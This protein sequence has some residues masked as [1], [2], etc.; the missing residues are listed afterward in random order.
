MISFGT[1]I[2][3]D[4]IKKLVEYQNLYNREQEIRKKYQ[5]EEKKMDKLLADNATLVARKND[6]EMIIYAT[7]KKLEEEQQKKLQLEQRLKEL[8][9]NKDKVK[10]T[11]QIK[12]WEKEMETLQQDLNMIIHQ[13]DYETHKQTDTMEELN[14]VNAKMLENDAKIKALRETIAAI[15]AKHKDELTYILETQKNI[16]S[17]FDV[18]VIEYFILLLRKTKGQAIVSV[19]DGD[20]CSG[21][22]TI[23]PTVIQGEIGPNLPEEEIELQQCPHC[24]RFLYYPQWLD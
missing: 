8:D 15:E 17:E 2:R 22:Y 16:A 24:F 6:L 12:T 21:C 11:R 18:S 23:L 10:I 19:L 4:K 5:D 20:T 7:Q 14:Q 3:L 9:E 13:I 1:G